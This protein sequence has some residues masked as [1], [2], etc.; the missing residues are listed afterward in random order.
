MAGWLLQYAGE[1]GRSST[2]AASELSL[3]IPHDTCPDIPPFELPHPAPAKCWCRVFT[4]QSYQVLFSPVSRSR[5]LYNFEC[6]AKM[7]TAAAAPQ[8]Q[9]EKPASSNT[10]KSYYFILPLR[11]KH[12]GF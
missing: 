5:V 4:V 6:R 12:V 11:G 1:A 9:A 8:T 10:G 3:V 7:D 2:V